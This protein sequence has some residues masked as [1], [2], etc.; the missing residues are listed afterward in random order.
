MRNDDDLLPKAPL[1]LSRSLDFVRTPAG[2]PPHWGVRSP[3]CEDSVPSSI[4][5]HLGRHAMSAAVA[6]AS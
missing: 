2:E 3:G 1:N 4:T 6:T 5:R